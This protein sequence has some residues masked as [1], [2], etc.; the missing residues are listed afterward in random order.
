[1]RRARGAEL[2]TGKSVG[3]ED[4]VMALEEEGG[5]CWARQVEMLFTGVELAGEPFV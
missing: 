3:A 4:M 1:M 5:F 2:V